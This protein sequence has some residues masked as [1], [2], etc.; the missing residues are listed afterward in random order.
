MQNA[1]L[2]FGTVVVGAM[3]LAVIAG[4]ALTW[5]RTRDRG[6]ATPCVYLLFQTAS[7]GLAMYDVSLY[8]FF[9]TMHYVE[10]H[11]LMAPRCF[12][13]PLDPN[14]G[15]DRLFGRL[16]RNRILFYAMIILVAGI[17]NF[18]IFSTMGTYVTRNWSSWPTPT[19][20]MLAVFNG[21]F[22]THYFVESFIW[23]FSNP[24]YRQSLSP[25]YSAHATKKPIAAM[26]Q[27]M[28]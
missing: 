13:T 2:V 9:L 3:L 6:A 4:H 7:A 21:L 14:S 26:P 23:K 16:R 27:A 1:G 28:A 8:F 11:V 18:M 20:I 19:R 10:Y 12:D 25:L 15:T 5:R 17:A 24:F 22:V